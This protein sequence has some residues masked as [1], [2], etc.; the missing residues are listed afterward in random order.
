M[1][2]QPISVTLSL[3]TGPQHKNGLPAALLRQ[4]MLRRLLRF[5]SELEVLDPNETGSLEVV[6]RF[7]TYR[8]VSRVVWAGWRRL[9][10]TGY[11]QL[12]V[13]ATSW[14]ADRLASKYVP[15]S[16]I[17]HGWMA[18]CLACLGVA[19]R[20]GAIT[21]IETAALHFQQW[22]DEVITECNY[23]DVNPRKCGAVLPRPLIR[24]VQREYELC[25]KI[26]VLSSV[27]RRSFE[28]F[29]YADKAVPVWPGVDHVY[30]APPAKPE[31]PSLFRVC[32]VGRVELAKGVGYLLQ[33]WNRLGLLRAELLL[34]GEIKPEMGPLLKRYASA[35]V[36]LVGAL[37]F[38]GVAAH[39]RQS[40][41]FAFPSVNEGL[42]MVLLEAMASGLPVVA[43][44]RTGA[45]DLITHGKEGFIVPARNVE[46][47]AEAILWCYRHPDETAAMGR[48]ARAK[49]EQQFTLSHHAE[50]QIALYRSLVRP[51]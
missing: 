32:Y 40:S 9:P 26:I 12:P 15:P 23:F 25:D 51:R 20:Q 21:L 7:H 39:Y 34:I 13:V 30:F 35:N 29:G 22:Q 46:A 16:S 4:G 50:R 37:P 47:L 6:R 8:A 42:G 43:T 10:G 14:L 24:R 1:K 36:R 3:A 5:G 44:D 48:A 2:A 27:A 11:S 31:P 18:L 28:K 17:F 38:K 19:K 41:M 49:V 45:P 33:A